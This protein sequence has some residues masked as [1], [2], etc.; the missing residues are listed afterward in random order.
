MND[1]R[2]S[3]LRRDSLSAAKQVL[4]HLDI[5]FGGQLQ[6][7]ATPVVDNETAELVEEFVFSLPKERSAP[8]QM[9]S[10]QEL[11]LLEVMCS[12]FQEQGKDSLRQAI[13]SALFSPQGNVA[14]GRRQSMLG[15]LVSM[16]IAVCRVPILNCT[17]SWM[18]K[19]PTHQ[20]M[21]LAKVLVEDYCGSVPGP[22]QALRDIITVKD[23]VPPSDLLE[24]VVAWVQ[25]D[26]QLTL[27]TFLSAPTPT[28]RPPGSL[29]PTP[30]LGLI[31]WCVKAPL[32]YRRHRKSPPWGRSPAR[33]PR[34]ADGHTGPLFSRLHL[35]VLQILVSVRE[36]L[37]E[38]HLFGRLGVL[39]L[40]G[41]AKLAG[42]L[43]R[44][45]DDEADPRD[46]DS[47]GAAE[48]ELALNRL[49]QALQ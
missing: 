6:K 18:Q 2:R 28:S 34:A 8:R 10:L 21:R 22:S 7:S 19:S 12:Y 39:P 13:F 29:D 38:R 40:E 15:K 37:A 1:I 48:T 27:L 33:D 32:A 36:H 31:R 11:Q 20:C 49:A 3:L 4:Y 42:E 17:A 23:L 45:V 24:M 47:D 35:C 43:V 5:L 25:D 9:T 41:V 16:A 44:L 30:L 14:D 46:K 26:S